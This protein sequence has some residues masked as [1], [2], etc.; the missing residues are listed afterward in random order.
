MDVKWRKETLLRNLKNVQARIAAA[1]HAA[2]RPAGSVRLVAV[3][4][5]RPVEDLQA[6][7][8]LGIHD[9][10]ESRMQEALKKKEELSLCDIAWHFIGTLQRKK[11]AVAVRNFD[12][13]HSVDSLALAESLAK[14]SG[15]KPVSVLLQVNPLNE[16]TKHGVLLP[17][18]ELLL[19]KM[20]SFSTLRVCGLMA[21]APVRGSLFPNDV[22]AAFSSME[23][24]F[25]LMKGQFSSSLPYFAELSM[26][27]SQDFEEAIHHGAT[28]VRIGSLL[29]EDM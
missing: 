2:G 27:M 8:S 14:V 15:E 17:E 18:V 22:E 28:L 7:V 9:I 4:K 23:N 13:I 25:Q 29:F 3:T 5:F 16:P 19:E 26:G 12:L 6:L 10:G 11:A 20:S 24:I 1:E 21:M